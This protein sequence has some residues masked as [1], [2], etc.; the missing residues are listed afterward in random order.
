VEIVVAAS[1]R[2]RERPRSC[3]H[4]LNSRAGA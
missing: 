1:E 3:L 4:W 2:D